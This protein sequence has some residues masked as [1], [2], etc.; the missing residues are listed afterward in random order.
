MKIN[1]KK[2]GVGVGLVSLGFA[3]A[4]Y[5]KIN[6]GAKETYTY[7]VL[8][9]TKPTTDQQWA[10]DNKKES[11]N[12]RTDK[13][14]QTMLESHQAK[15]ERLTADYAPQIKYPDSLRAEFEKSGMDAQEVEKQTN[16]KLA[17]MKWELDK[18]NQSI[19]RMQKEIEL[20]S[21]EDIDRTEDLNY[22]KN[23]PYQK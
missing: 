10:E 23:S 4:N 3:G 14:L 1:L 22:I 6:F 20:R 7:Q 13:E 8:E 12:F 21:K 18:M 15:L 16:E 5:D 2:I 11:L 17:N 19:E 9:W